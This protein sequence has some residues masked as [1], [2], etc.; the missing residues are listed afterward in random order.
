MG[1]VLTQGGLCSFSLWRSRQSYKNLGT[2]S[3]SPVEEGRAILVAANL[4][5]HTIEIF[6]KGYLTAVGVD[7]EGCGLAR[8]RPGSPT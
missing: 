3:T 1:V 2:T 4:F 5:H 6:M 7:E 8:D